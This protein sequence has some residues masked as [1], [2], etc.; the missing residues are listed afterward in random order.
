MRAYSQSEDRL[1]PSSA[2]NSTAAARPVTGASPATS[3]T[4]A[5][6][7]PTCSPPAPRPRLRPGHPGRTGHRPVRPRHPP[8]HGPHRAAPRAVRRHV[9]AG[10]TGAFYGPGGPGLLGGPPARQKLYSRLRSTDDA[11]RIWELRGTDRPALRVTATGR[12]GGRRHSPRG[13]VPDVGRTGRSTD[14]DECGPRGRPPVE[15]PSWEGLRG[16]VR[17]GVAHLG[18]HL[19]HGTP[20]AVQSAHRQAGAGAGEVPQHGVVALP[21]R[22]EER[23][24]LVEFT[25]AGAFPGAAKGFGGTGRSRRRRR[26][27]GRVT[28]KWRARVVDRTSGGRAPPSDSTSAPAAQASVPP[29]RVRSQSRTAVR[30]PGP[31]C[32]TRRH[33]GTGLDHLR[34]GERR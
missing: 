27:S 11:R 34:A 14:A 20:R 19:V 23:L 28:P 17:D 31:A 2:W 25:P 12:A 30:R 7:P 5:S 18:G 21:G 22:R 1:R 6:P 15:G 29:V 3:P 4:R 33:V 13:A 10:R 24:G 32:A 16:Q 8:R 9:A 26:P